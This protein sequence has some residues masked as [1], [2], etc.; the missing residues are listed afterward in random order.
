MFEVAG[1]GT[2]DTMI[3][4]ILWWMAAMGDLEDE[5]DDEED[6]DHILDD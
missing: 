4:E 5:D 3:S 1:E 2:L 6:E